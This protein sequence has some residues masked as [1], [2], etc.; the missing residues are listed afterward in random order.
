MSGTGL[1]CVQ[2]LD[3]STHP[4]RPGADKLGDEF[5]SYQSQRVLKSEMCDVLR[6]TNMFGL[7]KPLG[8]F[9][10]KGSI[11]PPQEQQ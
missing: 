3:S 6:A 4:T 7:A 9:L 5:V 8:D 11:A 2:T 10:K 1:P